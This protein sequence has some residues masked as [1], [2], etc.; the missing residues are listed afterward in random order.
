MSAYNPTNLYV[1]DDYA[2]LIRDYNDYTA[3]REG[4]AGKH[5]N[6]HHCRYV[7]DLDNLR[8][9]PEVIDAARGLEYDN[10]YG[11]VL[12]DEQLDQIG[13]ALVTWL[14]LPWEFTRRY[15]GNDQ[16]RPRFDI[17][18]AAAEYILENK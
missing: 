3:H 2:T 7:V 10:N 6:L 1:W 15:V 12:S 9:N 16:Y 18:E 14:P 11:G 8:I 5:Y 4:P 13:Q 17:A